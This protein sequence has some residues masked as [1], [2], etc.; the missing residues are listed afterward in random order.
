MPVRVRVYAEKEE[1]VRSIPT[2]AGNG[3]V[4]L[5]VNE[6]KKI[7]TEVTCPAT[8]M[9]IEEWG[10]GKVFKYLL[11]LK[12]N[13]PFEEIL[14]IP[15]TEK[16][17]T[18]L[19]KKPMPLTSESPKVM[20]IAELLSRKFPSL[21]KK[22]KNKGS[23]VLIPTFIERNDVENIERILSEQSKT[24]REAL[25]S[26]FLDTDDD[27]KTAESINITTCGMVPSNSGLGSATQI[28]NYIA[29]CIEKIEM[30]KKVADGLGKVEEMA[31]AT[32]KKMIFVKA[33]AKYA[34]DHYL[35]YEQ[36]TNKFWKAVHGLKHGRVEEFDIEEE[37]EEVQQE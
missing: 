26:L 21:Y 31:N 2:D 19:Y 28:R 4:R 25:F 23:E 12:F 5:L 27:I 1:L 7:A 33:L 16:E 6:L 34:N 11:H 36:S 17:A 18:Q 9:F 29:R 35:E 14:N 37:P 8:G 13:K 3:T 10:R 24:N 32:G 22:S 30:F 15:K 20:I